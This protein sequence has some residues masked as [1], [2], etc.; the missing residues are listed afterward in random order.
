M[1]EIEIKLKIPDETL[2]KSRIKQSGAKYIG[3]F[4]QRDIWFDTEDKQFKRKGKGFRIRQQKG[5]ITLTLKDEQTFGK[6]RK[7]EEL[8]VAVDNFKNTFEILR[9]LGFV[10]DVEIKKERE[11]WVLGNIELALDI[12]EKL[13]IFLEL[14]GPQKI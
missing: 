13:G 2:V 9:R 5:E 11:I 14:E 10:V 7:A 1:K 12:V 8:E 6:V 3:K 4:F